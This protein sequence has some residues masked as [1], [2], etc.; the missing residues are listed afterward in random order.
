MSLLREGPRKVVIWPFF[1]DSTLSWSEGR[2][3]PRALAVKKPT[4]DEVAE[5]ARRAGYEVIVDREAKH[6]A[7]WFDSVGRVL[8]VTEEKKTVVIRKIAKELPKVRALRGKKG[9]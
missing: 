5:A 8:V 9:R 4:L 7:H 6:P 3:V 2:R 1:F